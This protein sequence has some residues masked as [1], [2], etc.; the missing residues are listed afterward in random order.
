MLQLLPEKHQVSTHRNFQSKMYTSVQCLYNH[1]ED[2]ISLQVSSFSM[3]LRCR[4]FSNC[5][6]SVHWSALPP[7]FSFP[8]CISTSATTQ[9]IA[10]MNYRAAA[11]I[12]ASEQQ[13][14]R[15][16]TREQSSSNWIS[17]RVKDSDGNPSSCNLVVQ[18]HHANQQQTQ[19]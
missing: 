5:S 1:L 18:R 6:F 10:A 12:R 17:A 13:S 7:V 8:C 16:T 9:T 15:K 11:F 19:D 2:K 4:T 14:I 3:V